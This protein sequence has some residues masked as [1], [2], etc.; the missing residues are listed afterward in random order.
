[1][2]PL[3]YV[4]LIM[5]GSPEM[6]FVMQLV[7]TFAAQITMLIIIKPLI[8]LSLKLYTIEVFLRPAIVTMLAAIVPICLYIF[9]DDGLI[10]S[11][12]VMASCIV[13]VALNI[14]FV[15]LNNAEKVLLKSKMELIL[16]KTRK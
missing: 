1:M 8:G 3:S 5:G 11:A 14:Y 2:I 12:L 6:V 9:L 10:S 7:T 16:N 13:S 15:G 4:A